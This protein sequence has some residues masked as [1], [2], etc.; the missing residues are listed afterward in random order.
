MLFYT[1]ICLLQMA[2]YNQLLGRGTK[3]QLR[4][5]VSFSAIFLAM[6]A[7]IFGCVLTH[8]I[9]NDFIYMKTRN[10]SLCVISN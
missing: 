8:A 4:S 5:L 9:L 3:W 7:F 10:I 1:G 2:E 6:G